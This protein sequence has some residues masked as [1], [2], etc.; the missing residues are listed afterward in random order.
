MFVHQL[1]AS[2][3][4]QTVCICD[5]EAARNGWVCVALASSRRWLQYPCRH[6]QTHG[7]HRYRNACQNRRR[8]WSARIVHALPA[9]LI[10]PRSAWWL[11]PVQSCLLLRFTQSIGITDIGVRSCCIHMINQVRKTASSSPLAMPRTPVLS[12]PA[13]TRMPKCANVFALAARCRCVQCRFE[14]QSVDR[15]RPISWQSCRWI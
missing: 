6:G 11:G 2:Y 12:R 10:A 15:L 3:Q 9:Q 5:G 1:A 4:H 14:R 13:V 7:I 8:R